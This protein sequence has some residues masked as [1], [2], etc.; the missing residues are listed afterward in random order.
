MSKLLTTEKDIAILL[1]FSTTKFNLQLHANFTEIKLFQKKTKQNKTEKYK[2]ITYRHVGNAIFE[3]YKN[4]NQ[5]LPIT[6]MSS[7][8]KQVAKTNYV[9][10]YD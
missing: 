10:A 3:W 2:F 5:N 1:Y 8:Q 4:V 9:Q 6:C 7:P